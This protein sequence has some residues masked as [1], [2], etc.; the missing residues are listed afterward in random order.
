MCQR[1]Q[2]NSSLPRH[3]R[4]SRPVTTFDKDPRKLRGSRLAS[5]RFRSSQ[6][7]QRAVSRGLG[8]STAR[9]RACGR[10]HLKSSQSGKASMSKGEHAQEG[11][12]GRGTGGI[13]NRKRAR[14]R[15]LRNSHVNVDKTGWNRLSCGH[16]AF[17]AYWNQNLLAVANGWADVGSQ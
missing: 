7:R 2:R 17:I 10:L 1:H 12:A 14:A 4:S 11:P 5:F 9:S 3:V 16:W 6:K 8:L 13:M 15:A